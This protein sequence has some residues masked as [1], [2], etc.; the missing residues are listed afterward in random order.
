MVPPPPLPLLLL[1]PTWPPPSLPTSLLWGFKW[2]AGAMRS[3]S[4]STRKRFFGA[5]ASRDSSDDVRS[6]FG[7]MIGLRET[8]LRPALAFRDA[9][10]SSARVQDAAGAI[11][12]AAAGAAAAATSAVALS[13]LLAVGVQ[14]GRGRNPLFEL[15][16]AEALLRGCLFRLR[17]RFRHL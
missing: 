1:P 9:V 10:P 16:H 3:S 14:M 6:V 11:A 5:S 8:G 7:S 17:S 15:L 2:A 13:N 4:F 12:A